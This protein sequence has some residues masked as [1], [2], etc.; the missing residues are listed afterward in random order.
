MNNAGPQP[1]IISITDYKVLSWL[2]TVAYVRT[3]GQIGHCCLDVKPKFE[4]VIV[5]NPF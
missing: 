4:K 5:D 2:N 3:E 1:K